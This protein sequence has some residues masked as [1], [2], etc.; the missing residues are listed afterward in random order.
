MLLAIATELLQLYSA[1][2]ASY[3]DFGLNLIGITLG[4]GVVLFWRQGLTAGAVTVGA[5]ALLLTLAAPAVLLAGDIKKRMIFPVL[6][7][8]GDWTLHQSIDGFAEAH[9]LSA[10]RWQAYQ[11]RSVTELRFDE[12]PERA[13][14][15]SHPV[16]FR[17]PVSDWRSY[18]AIRADIYSPYSDALAVHFVARHAD[19]RYPRRSTVRFAKRGQQCLLRSVG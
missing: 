12:M 11:H 2:S 7:E 18:G 16:W 5:L 15:P 9:V 13:D 1:R 8:P 17:E 6:H 19:A 10:H 4:L 14:R 3:A